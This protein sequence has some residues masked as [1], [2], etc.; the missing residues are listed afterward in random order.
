MFDFQQSKSV[1]SA[2]QSGPD[3]G[4]PNTLYNAEEP[5]GP[6]WRPKVAKNPHRAERSNRPQSAAPVS[7][8]YSAERATNLKDFGR[9]PMSTRRTPQIQVT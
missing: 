9:R 6:G 1:I 4:E 5:A 8:A 3:Y 2:A 7:S